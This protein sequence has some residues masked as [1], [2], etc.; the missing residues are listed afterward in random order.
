MLPKALSNDICSLN[1]HE[2]RLTLSVDME[3]T[4]DGTVVNHEIYESVINS[5]ERLVYDDVSDLLENNDEVIA[6]KYKDIKEELF[7]MNDLALALRKNRSN[8][9][10]LDFDLDE[11]YI[12][13]DERG[14]PVSVEIASRRTANKLIEEFMLLANETVAEHFYWMEMPF[15]YRVHEKPD[16]EKIEKL[17]VFLRSFG[18]VLRGNADSIHPKAISNVLEQVAG[19][20]NETVVNSVTLRSMQKAFLQHFMRR[21]FWT[22][23]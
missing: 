20:T 13:L 14:V 7:M 15:V 23:T 17:K 9:G 5:H 1:P 11:S 2:D 10:S 8:R 18:I 22:G 21:T 6:E 3:V 19:Q 12:R 16:T 4:A